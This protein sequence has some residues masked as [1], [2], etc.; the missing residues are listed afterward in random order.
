MKPYI[1][2][3]Q[4]YRNHFGRGDTVFQ[5]ARRQ[6]GYGAVKRFAV[7]LISKGIKFAAPFV[8]TFARKAIGKIAPNSQWAQQISDMAID[9]LTKKISSGPLIEQVVGVG[10]KKVK[11]LFKKRK[12]PIAVSRPAKRK[13]ENIFY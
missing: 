13:K 12:R 11:Y 7:P 5:G 4:V 10:E 3:P 2:N 8:K 1:H 6:R 9:K